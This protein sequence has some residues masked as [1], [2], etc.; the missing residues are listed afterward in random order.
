MK[1]EKLLK[2][3]ECIKTLRILYRTKTDTNILDA[4][5]YLTASVEKESGVTAIPAYIYDEMT[6]AEFLQYLGL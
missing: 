2:L 5:E 3:K 4:V 6:D 1:K